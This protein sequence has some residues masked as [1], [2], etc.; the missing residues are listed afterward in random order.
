M[1]EIKGDLFNSKECLVHCVSKDFRMGAGIAKTFKQKFGKV[2]ELLKQNIEIGDFAFL[3]KDDKYIFYLVTKERYYNKPKLKD[4][5]SS[6]KVLYKFCI[7]NKIKSLSMPK[8]GCG[9]DKQNWTDVSKLLKNIFTDIEIT[10][11]YL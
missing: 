10:V 2:D 11:Y 9:L 3:K 5:E 6:L 4:I 7:K 8:I 1:K